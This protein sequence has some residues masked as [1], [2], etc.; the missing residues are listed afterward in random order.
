M[1][2]LLTND[3]GIDSEGI[4]V[5]AREL[6]RVADVVLSVP[7][8]E[9]SGASHSV[10][11]QAPV[12]YRE[13]AG[14]GGIRGYVVRGT[15]VDCVRLAYETLE[16]PFDMVVSGI[17]SG[18]NVG[19]NIHYSGTVA[20]AVEAAFLGLRGLAVSIST[21]R[22]ENYETAARYAVELVR[23][24][25]ECPRPLVVNLNVPDL[26]P[27]EVRGVRITR[28]A[29]TEE[30]TLVSPNENSRKEVD[31]CR[32]PGIV[33][34]SRAIVAGY[35]SITPLQVDLTARDALDIVQ[36]WELGAIER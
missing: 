6:D 29:V 33:L 23:R 31:E 32:H 2:L 17:N 20:A 19:I 24:M 16:V 15:P 8:N 1:G 4:H 26:P 36:G 10:T 18:A 5:L 25:R 34:D 35:V 13:I 7:E 12:E 28:T 3:D 9:R 11:L 14:P 21:R 22:P 30:E 27:G